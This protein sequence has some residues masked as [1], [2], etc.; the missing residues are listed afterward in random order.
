MRGKS[1]DIPESS[2]EDEEEDAAEKEDGDSSRGD[3]DNNSSS[4][5][6][7]DTGA[8]AN[9]EHKDSSPKVDIVN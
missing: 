7:A 8:R 2:S 4:G 3:E 6:D 1:A 5:S 9:S